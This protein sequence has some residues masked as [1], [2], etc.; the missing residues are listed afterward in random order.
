M[1]QVIRCH[2][3]EMAPFWSL[4]W[5]VRGGWKP[6]LLALRGPVLIPGFILSLFGIWRFSRPPRRFADQMKLD[7]RGAKVSEIRPDLGSYGMGSPGFLGFRLESIKDSKSLWVVATLWNA[8]RGTTVNGQKVIEAFSAEERRHL[9]KHGHIAIVALAHLIG[10]C[11]EAI[12]VSSEAFK[13]RFKKSGGIFYELL[14]QQSKNESA[15]GIGS[16]KSKPGEHRESL[17]NAIIISQKGKL[18]MQG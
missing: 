9:S 13:I 4:L 18:W 6:D 17:V 16:Q 3:E 1:A 5:R 12:G 14:I 2:E 7:L 8:V 11:I 10:S 15:P